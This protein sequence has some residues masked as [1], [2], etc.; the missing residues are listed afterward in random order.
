MVFFNLST[1]ILQLQLHPKT[2]DYKFCVWEL[3]AYLF[4]LQW[5]GLLL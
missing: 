3:I 5:N 2:G 4:P 1:F